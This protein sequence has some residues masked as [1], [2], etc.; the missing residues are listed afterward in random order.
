M[1]GP[2]RAYA[3]GRQWGVPRVIGL[4]GHTLAVG[5]S[6]KT[7]PLTIYEVN[8]TESYDDGDVVGVEWG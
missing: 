6:M 8:D 3:R 1:Y 5:V 7:Q 4:D 2:S